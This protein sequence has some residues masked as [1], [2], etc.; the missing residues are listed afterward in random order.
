MV[1]M[2]NYVLC[3]FSQFLR[4]ETKSLLSRGACS[5]GA[6]YILVGYSEYS[7]WGGELALTPI[8]SWPRLL[9]QMGEVCTQFMLALLGPLPAQAVPQAPLSLLGVHTETPHK[10]S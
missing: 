1:T 4:R 3:A 9:A 7:I 2:V 6:I 5:G 8:Q 10:G